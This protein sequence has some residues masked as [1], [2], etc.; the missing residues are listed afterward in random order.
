[1]EENVNKYTKKSKVTSLYAAPAVLLSAGLIGVT[2]LNCFVI[3]LIKY[4]QRMMDLEGSGVYKF[5][6]VM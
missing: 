4:D 2:I 6:V 1:M 3:N 5:T